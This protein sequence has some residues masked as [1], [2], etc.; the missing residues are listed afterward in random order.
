MLVCPNFFGL[1]HDGAGNSLPVK[2]L[3]RSLKSKQKTAFKPKIDRLFPL[4]FSRVPGPSYLGNSY[5]FSDPDDPG[6]I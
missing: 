4:P 2:P 1:C 3:L 5:R 6:I